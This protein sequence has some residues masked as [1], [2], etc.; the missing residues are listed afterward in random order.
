MTKVTW[1]WES[2]SPFN[3]KTNSSITEASLSKAFRCNW[4]SVYLRCLCSDPGLQQVDLTLSDGAQALIKLTT[5]RHTFTATPAGCCSSQSLKN[6]REPVEINSRS[7]NTRKKEASCLEDAWLKPCWWSAAGSE[8]TYVFLVLL[9]RV[10]DSLV[11]QS[12]R[13]CFYW[14]FHVQLAKR[15]CLWVYLTCFSWSAL[16]LKA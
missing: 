14:F 12:S 1:C 6:C 8:S 13:L 16:Q 5:W 9:L 2:E 10:S 15:N 7:S 3:K 11:S 4:W